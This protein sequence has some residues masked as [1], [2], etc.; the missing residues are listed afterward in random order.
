MD[1]QEDD[2]VGRLERLRSFG[3]PGGQDDIESWA[4]RAAAVVA[5]IGQQNIITEEPEE[6]EEAY[7]LMLLLLAKAPVEVI[8]AASLFVMQGREAVRR[9]IADLN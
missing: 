3:V 8:V 7:R 2:F 1:E 4:V 5:T 9:N 6:P